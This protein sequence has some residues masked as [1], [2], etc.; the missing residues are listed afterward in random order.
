MD[1]ILGHMAQGLGRG[2]VVAK[3]T[4]RVGTS[5]AGIRPSAQKINE[6]VASKLDGEH[7][8]DD[9]QVGDEGR[10]EDD[11]DVGGVEQLDGVGGVLATVA[12]GLDWQIH[13]EALQVEKETNIESLT[14]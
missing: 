6:E 10:L 5:A 3:A 4:N 8:G 12:G 1:G 7:L 13:P 14:M 9:I 11:G 2:Q